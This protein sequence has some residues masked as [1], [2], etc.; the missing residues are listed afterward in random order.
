MANETAGPIILWENYGYEGWKP[1]SFPTVRD[2]LAA[3]RFNSEFVITRVADFQ[4][5]E[6]STPPEAH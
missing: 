5:V 6:C 4:V 1:T 3:Q 2:A